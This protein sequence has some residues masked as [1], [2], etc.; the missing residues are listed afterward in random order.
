MYSLD[1]PEY[2]HIISWNPTGLSFSITDQREF[3]AKVLP[4]LFKVAKFTSFQRKV[5]KSVMRNPK[6][7]HFLQLAGA[8]DLASTV[9]CFTQV[10]H[11]PF[12][13][14]LCEAQSLGLRK[15]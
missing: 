4:E 10:S 6:T 12:P 7:N 1:C 5:R 3:E 9:S 11:H 14:H 2:Q 15:T 8:A 13:L